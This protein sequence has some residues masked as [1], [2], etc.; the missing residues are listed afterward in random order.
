MTT[1]K[2]V[3]LTDHIIRWAEPLQEPTI[4][5]ILRR[6]PGKTAVIDEVTLES[7][8]D[9]YY[10][11]NDAVYVCQGHPRIAVSQCRRLLPSGEAVHETH[12]RWIPDEEWNERQAA[13]KRAAAFETLAE[14]LREALKP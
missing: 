4:V 14:V 5:A 13:T 3:V 9:L 7:E 10:P 12:A 6:H 11:S 8:Y 2:A 1:P